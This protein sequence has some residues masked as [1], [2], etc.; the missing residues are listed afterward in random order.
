MEDK[1]TVGAE[2]EGGKRRKGRLKE[3]ETREWKVKARTKG[4]GG[5]RGVRRADRK[6]L[7]NMKQQEREGKD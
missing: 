7:R 2:N 1:R 4:V 3:E 6:R 5:G